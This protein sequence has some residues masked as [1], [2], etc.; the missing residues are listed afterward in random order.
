MGDYSKTKSGLGAQIPD[1]AVETSWDDCGPLI[2]PEEVRRIHLWGIPLVSAIKNPMTGKAD[3]MDDGL[4]SRFI[5]EAVS[6]AEMEAHIEIF[7]RIHDERHPYDQKA[8]DSFGYMVVRHRPVQSIEKLSITSSDNV[9]IWDVPLAWVDTGYLH[10][11]QIQMMPFAV[12]T[13]SGGT[14]PIIS[15]TGQGLLPSLFRFNWVPGLWNVSYTTGFRNGSIPKIVNHLIGVVAAMETLSM[16]ATTY[17]RSQSSSLGIDG[18][19]QSIST[20]GPQLFDTRLGVLA[21]K[22][23]WLIRKIQR[24]CGLGFWSDNV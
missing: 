16:L 5:E 24:T 12:G 22:R 14:I 17:A 2:T 4:L 13:Q 1:G 11:G 6:L 7:P 19:S 3:V 10:Q 8:M 15:P 18:L 20:P 23:K 21:E 9:H